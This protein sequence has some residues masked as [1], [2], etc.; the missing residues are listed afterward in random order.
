LVDEAG[1]G[2]WHMGVNR[3]GGV[4]LLPALEVLLITV[5]VMAVKCI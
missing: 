3:C 2:C 4:S 5:P 1:V